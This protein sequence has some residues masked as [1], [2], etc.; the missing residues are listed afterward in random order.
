M[1]TGK[2]VFAQL[3]SLLPTYE[4]KECVEKFKGNHRV[5]NFTRKEHF[6]VMGFSQLTYR[7][8]LR[9]IES[10]LTAFSKK[11][12]HSGIKQPV[13]KSTLAEANESRDWR[14]YADYAQVLIKEARHLYQK[15]NEFKLDVKN[16]VYALVA[17]PS[18][19]A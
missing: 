1:N 17:A 4:F 8:N 12:Y 3:M 7:E 9:D 13:P 16:I 2:T 10:C 19:Y 14:I 5:R 6:Y 18:T 15:D 11:L